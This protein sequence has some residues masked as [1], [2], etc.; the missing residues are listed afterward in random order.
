LFRGGDFR[1]LF[2]MHEK[3]NNFFYFWQKIIFNVLR[4]RPQDMKFYLF[5]WADELNKI[6]WIVKTIYDIER[7]FECKFNC[8]DAY[9]KILIRLTWPMKIDQLK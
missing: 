7:Y 9:R 3:W 5:Q 8:F 4:S 6:S 1:G 2:F